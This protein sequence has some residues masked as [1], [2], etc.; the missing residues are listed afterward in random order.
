MEELGK[1]QDN[2]SSHDDNESSIHLSNN[3][4][5][6]SKIKHIQMRY[7]FIQSILEDGHLNLEKIHTSHNP[8][9]MLTKGVT[10]EKFARSKKVHSPADTTTVELLRLVSKW[11]IVGCGAWLSSWFRGPCFQ[12][13][14]YPMKTLHPISM[15]T[16]PRGGVQSGGTPYVGSKLPCKCIL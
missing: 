15:Y 14:L 3:P 9:D 11:E 12:P 1:N 8:A 4:S 7:H 2:N 16:L 10:R 13:C 6:H 5:F